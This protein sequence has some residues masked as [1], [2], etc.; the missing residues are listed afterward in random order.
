MP[1]MDYRYKG[2]A[3]KAAT[4]A[5]RIAERGNIKRGASESN[6][7]RIFSGRHDPSFALLKEIAEIEGYTLC[8]V[9]EMVEEC[10]RQHKVMTALPEF[11]GKEKE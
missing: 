1:T 11:F 6:L 4:L 9:V 8:Q 2:K 10:R 3:V 7:S 5:R